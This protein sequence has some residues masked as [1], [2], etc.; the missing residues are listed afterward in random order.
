MC[1]AIFITGSGRRTASIAIEQPHAT[2]KMPPTN[3]LSIVEPA[4][5]SPDKTM[6][7]YELALPIVTAAVNAIKPRA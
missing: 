2:E 7:I 3:G 1:R 6:A 5:A 4:S